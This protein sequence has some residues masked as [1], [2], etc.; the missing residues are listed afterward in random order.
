MTLIIK[1]A[2]RVRVSPCKTPD[3]CNGRPKTCHSI[4]KLQVFTQLHAHEKTKPIASRMAKT[5]QSFGHS[6]C[7]MVKHGNFK[8]ITLTSKTPHPYHKHTLAIPPHSL[9][10]APHPSKYTTHSTFYLQLWIYQYII[11]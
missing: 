8:P 2:S 10:E 1:A 7:N 5:P 6:E 3:Q 9:P 11:I 4:V